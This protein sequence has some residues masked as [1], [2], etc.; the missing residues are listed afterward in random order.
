MSNCWKEGV[1]AKTIASWEKRYKDSVNSVHDSNSPSKAASSGAGW[2]ETY[3][4]VSY[5]GIKEGKDANGNDIIKGDMFQKPTSGGNWALKKAPVDTASATNVRNTYNALNEFK[6]AYESSTT[7]EKAEQDS[8]QKTLVENFAASEAATALKCGDDGGDALAA[9]ALSDYT[10]FTEKLPN[11][12]GKANAQN[13]EEQITVG[14]GD[15]AVTK[16]MA[17]WEALMK[18]AKTKCADAN[19]NPGA[20]APSSASSGLA[21]GVLSAGAGETQRAADAAANKAAACEDYKNALAAL[22]QA[23]E[24]RSARVATAMTARR[25]ITFKEQCFL[26]ANVYKLAPYKKALDEMPAYGRPKRLPYV[27]QTGQGPLLANGGRNSSLLA[28]GDPFAFINKLTQH[29]RSKKAFMKIETSELS[30]LQ[31]MIRLFKIVTDTK[32]HDES[33]IEMKFDSHYTSGD[34]DDFTNNEKTRGHGVGIKSFNITYEADNPFAVKKSIRAK[35]VLHANTFDELLRE[36]VGKNSDPKGPSTYQ[37]IDLALKTGG[38][39]G[40]SKIIEAERINPQE[41][42][43]VALQNLSK[44][45]FRLK[46]IVGWALPNNKN[47]LVTKDLKQAIEDSCISLNLTP[48][49]HEFNIDDQGRVE[50]VLNYLAYVEDFYDQPIY[51]I[52]NDPSVTA[53]LISRKLRYKSYNKKCDASAIST[54]RSEEKEAMDEETNTAMRTLVKNLL[55]SGRMQFLEVELEALAQFQAAGPLGLDEAQ[56]AYIDGV[57][58]QILT[59]PDANT[60]QGGGG[61]SGDA[62]QEV[63]L[64]LSDATRQETSAQQERILTSD[65]KTVSFFYAADLIDIILANI[66]DTLQDA[67]TLIDGIS[68]DGITDEHKTAEK[69]LYKLYHENFQ[70]FRLVL[71]PMELVSPAT[72]PGEKLKSSFVCLGDIPVSLRYF[73]EWLTKKLLKKEEA[74]YPLPRFLNDFLNEF[75]RNFLNNDTCFNNLSKQSVR[76]AQSAI[77]SYRD[78]D[79]GNDEITQTILDYSSEGP[80]HPEAVARRLYMNNPKNETPI[81]NISGGRNNNIINPGFAREINY[82]VYYAARTQPS[83][84]MNG[85]LDEDALHGITHYQIGKQDGIV[86]TINLTKTDSPGLKEV[87]FEQEGYDGLQQ[88][89]EMYDAKIKTY[90]DVSAFP[91]NYIFIEPAG[92]S[93]SAR[94]SGIDLTQ[95][96]IGGYYMI[97][98]SEHAFGA[99]LGETQITAKWVAEIAQLQEDQGNGTSASNSPCEGD[100]LDAGVGEG[101]PAEVPVSGIAPSPATSTGGAVGPAGGTTPNGGATTTAPT[102][103]GTSGQGQAEAYMQYYQGP[104]G[105]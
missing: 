63:A 14:S 18:T 2:S 62:A 91:G 21:G 61:G 49:I 83:D 70:K 12:E 4:G 51:N 44:L 101:T 33:Q 1:S 11:Q 20:P 90:S 81:L 84:R 96:G 25:N 40:V 103:P 55:S 79:N 15:D 5:P 60:L 105:S 74:I 37:Y 13:P 27:Y 69:Q 80:L 73:M 38:Y 104:P 93:P 78:S 8:T 72:Q 68:A 48:T 86:K 34:W 88:L 42:N 7:L 92:F 58:Q 36:R 66:G 98:R 47:V 41:S 10:A 3:T 89:R 85:D 59:P 39:H 57:F 23:K 16:S 82:L 28:Q 54:M 31:P 26:L 30:N 24:Q 102:T 64:L 52:F 75:L 76:L 67:S 46:A 99:G 53:S 50:F 100:R 77:T 19:T 56:T 6:V 71:G 95:F 87:R 94:A 35:L 65:I 29:T 43:T 9:L 97:I 22:E 45:A 17:E 32:T